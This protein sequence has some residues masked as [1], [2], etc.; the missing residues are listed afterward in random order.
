MREFD[1]VSLRLFVATCDARSIARVGEKFNIVPSAV[2]KRLQQLETHTG[3]DL[4]VRS[5]SGVFPTPAGETL[6]EYA[7]SMLFDADR[8]VR[9]MDAFVSGIRGKIRLLATLSAVAESLPEDVA[10]FMQEK[11]HQGVQVD[12]EETLSR[13][14]VRNLHAGVASVGICWDAAEL[15]GVKTRPYRRDHLGVVTHPSHPLAT[16]RSCCFEDTLD[17]EQVGLHPQTAGYRLLARAAEAAGKQIQYR[18]L[19]S[20]FDAVLRM[21]RAKLGITVAPIEIAATYAAALGL[22][23]IPLTDDWAIRQLVICYRDEA[24]LSP[25]AKS[26]VDYLALQGESDAPPPV[27]QSV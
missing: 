22:K 27:T 21:V 20:T 26:L 15:D 6:L 9:D 18:S 12:I 19:L 13:D 8:A 17:Y 7:R 23:V 14:I 5:K 11:R 4:L 2:S 24:I 10:N 16:L 3:V 25:A 1:L